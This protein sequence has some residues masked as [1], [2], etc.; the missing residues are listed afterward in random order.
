M[1]SHSEHLVRLL[2][3]QNG[4]CNGCN[5]RLKDSYGRNV[6]HFAY[7][8]LGIMKPPEAQ[9]DHIWPVSK[10]HLYRGNI[11]EY[12][13]LQVLCIYCNRRKGDKSLCKWLFQMYPSAKK[14]ACA[15]VNAHLNRRNRYFVCSNGTKKMILYCTVP[16]F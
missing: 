4:R 7:P 1:N 2:R 15:R 16:I 9:V 14:M 5:L 3:E 10:S 6:G 8:P 13:N 11:D 12:E